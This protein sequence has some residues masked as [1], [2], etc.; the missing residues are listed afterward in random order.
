MLLLL[1]KKSLTVFLNPTKACARAHHD[2]I[3]HIQR[4]YE[5]P[6]YAIITQNWGACDFG[7]ERWYAAKV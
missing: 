5:S 1:V 3:N 7:Y 2:A 4:Y 6:N